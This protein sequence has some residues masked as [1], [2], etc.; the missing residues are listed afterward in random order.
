MYRVTTPTHTFTL[1]IDTS[2]C[3]EI[4]L[5]YEQGSTV[6]EKHYQDNTLPDGMTLDGTSVIQVLTQEE[7][8]A[9]CRGV[10]KAQ[11]RVLTTA[12]K[13]YTSQKFEIHV[14]DT[15]NEDILA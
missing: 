8:K 14:K 6:L 5:T 10:V 12:G 1:P 15:L 7:T 4:L 13:A 3:S 2:T 9:F 11:I